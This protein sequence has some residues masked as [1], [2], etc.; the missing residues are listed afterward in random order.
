MLTLGGAHCT[1]GP[2]PHDSEYIDI[3]IFSSAV[4]H[5]CVINLT[6][7][8]KN[9]DGLLG[10]GEI[11]LCCVWRRDSIT[12]EVRGSLFISEEERGSDKPSE[13]HH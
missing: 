12:G 7:F 3:S 5:E 8:C 4:K 11:T 10:G 6:P 9:K 13:P 2:E 1:H